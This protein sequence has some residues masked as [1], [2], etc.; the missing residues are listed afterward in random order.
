VWPQL[1]QLACF[2]RLVELTESTRIL[3][4]LGQP[5]PNH[6]YSELK[7]LPLPCFLVA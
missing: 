7:A 3:M 6:Q 5:Q 1:Q 4:D 2:Q